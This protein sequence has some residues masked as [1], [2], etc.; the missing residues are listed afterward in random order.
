MTVF[1]EISPNGGSQPAGKAFA[2][3]QSLEEAMQDIQ[4]SANSAHQT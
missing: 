3:T 2:V 1:V 4:V